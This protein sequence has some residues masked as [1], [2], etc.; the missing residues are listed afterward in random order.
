MQAKGQANNNKAAHKTNNVLCDKL[1]AEV[2]TEH[3]VH[4]RDSDR[5]GSMS[6]SMEGAASSEEENKKRKRKKK[7]KENKGNK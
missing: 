4:V 7:T 2:T 1:I 5:G 6:L 3:G